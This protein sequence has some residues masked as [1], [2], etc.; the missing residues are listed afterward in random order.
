V[1]VVAAS[2]GII[3]VLVRWTALPA[4]A[5]VW[6]RTA[7]GAA[8]LVPVRRRWARPRGPVWSATG[9][10]PYV[11]GPLLAAHWLALVAAQQRAPIGTVLLITYLSPVVVAVLA[12]PILHE[13]VPPLVV[14]ALGVA[15]LGTWVLARPSGHA[16]SGEAFAL[17][18]AF[19]Y[20]A[21]ILVAKHMASRVDPITYSLVEL[22][23]AALVLAPF[24]ATAHW[25]APSSDWW[26]LVV[27]GVVF[28]G[29][30]GPVFIGL[31]QQLPATTVGVL[32]YLEPV[33]AVACGWLFLGESPGGATL[34][35][36]MLIVFAGV[37]V[38]VAPARR[39]GASARVPR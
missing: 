25:G 31:L 9:A 15:V 1:S 24:A 23:G 6:G 17:I 37:V 7:I 33:S 12:G 18:A 32:S 20:A 2:W 4:V 34:V 22:A 36:G 16:G 39:Q 26:W 8:V 27:L 29:I 30:L 3:G 21:L 5:I 10:W 28:T 11:V 35:G 38:V 13:R 14:V 19:T